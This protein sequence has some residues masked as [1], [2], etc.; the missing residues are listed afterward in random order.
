MN[1]I[2]KIFIATALFALTGSAHAIV[3][4]FKAMA[5]PGGTLGESAWTALSFNADG[6]HSM[7]NAFLDITSTNGRAAPVVLG[8]PGAGGDSMLDLGFFL[9]AGGMFDVGFDVNQS[10]NNSEIT[11][12][13]YISKIEFSTVPE[14][15]VL[16][17]PGI[18][19]VGIGAAR[20]LN[21]K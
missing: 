1:T 4:D 8:A 16:A 2:R 19:L 3:I 7:V 14:P 15:A 10:C 6:S 11:A 12:S 9:G 13:F 21:K 17:L 5:E 20:R 18:D